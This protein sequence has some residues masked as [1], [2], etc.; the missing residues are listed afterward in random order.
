MNT[1]LISGLVNTE[2]TVRVRQFPIE[3]YPIDYPF[4]GVDTAVSGVA[5]NVARALGTLGDAVR[6]LSM[7]GADFPADFIRRELE[8]VKQDIAQTDGKEQ[9][10]IT[11]IELY[12]IAKVLGVPM[13]ALFEPEKI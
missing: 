6:F 2:T 13:E 3:Y 10:S 7:T 5:W 11:D 4:F 12:G 1:I 9:A 8:L